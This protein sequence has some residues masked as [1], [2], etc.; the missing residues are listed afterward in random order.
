M[1][2]SLARLNEARELR[3]IALTL[4]DRHGMNVILVDRHR[5]IKTRQHHVNDL[6]IMQSAPMGEQIL[7]VYH[8][9]KVFSVNWNDVDALDVVA[10]K[11]GEWR[12]VLRAS[13]DQS[14]KLSINGA[15]Q[16]VVSGV[17]SVTN[18]QLNS[19]QPDEWL[20]P[21]HTMTDAAAEASQQSRP[22]DASSVNHTDAYDGLSHRIRLEFD[23][24]SRSL[25]VVKLERTDV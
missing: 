8:G 6:K 1:K 20:Q 9:R 22:G 24:V 19:L 14:S 4:L 3:D 18:D 23:P 12:Q 11:P 10:F 7:D 25:R 16:R 15:P 5:Q 2:V 13:G 17:I 21:L